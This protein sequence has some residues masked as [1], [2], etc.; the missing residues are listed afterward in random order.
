[1]TL[2]NRVQQVYSK[3]YNLYGRLGV[4]AAR[5]VAINGVVLPVE[6]LIEP[7][8]PQLLT[9]LN[10]AY[11]NVKVN[12]EDLILRKVPRYFEGIYTGSTC[13]TFLRKGKYL[14]DARLDSLGVLIGT[15]AECYFVDSSKSSA[16]VD[17]YLKVNRQR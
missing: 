17:V 3:V 2:V 16:S 5:T 14:L 10:A 12:G 13:E 15:Q 4:D 11:P 6:I 9:V 8:K 7:I 1:M